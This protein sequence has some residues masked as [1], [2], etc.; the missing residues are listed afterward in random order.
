M[1]RGLLVLIAIAVPVCVAVAA[2]FVVSRR[3][4]PRTPMEAARRAV[5]AASR[6]STRLGR[7]GL[8]GKGSGNN[9]GDSSVHGG[10]GL[11]GH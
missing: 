9:F 8:R 2:V 1:D 3:R 11:S 6:E 7:S 4:R 5:R 10:D